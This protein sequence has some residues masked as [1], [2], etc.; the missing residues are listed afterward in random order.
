MTVSRNRDRRI[1]VR[2]LPTSLDS[3]CRSRW[4]PAGAV[5]GWHS[6]RVEHDGLAE[7]VTRLRRLV[8]GRRFDDLEWV[9]EVDSTNAV[10]MARAR[11]GDAEQALLTDF[12]SA[13]RGRRDRRW[14]APPGSSLMVSVLVRHGLDPDRSGHLTM[15]FGLAAADACQRCCGVRPQLKW[16]ND[17]VHEDRKLAGILAE[18][19][20]EGTTMTAAVIGMGMNTGWPQLPEDL[21]QTA[22]SLNLL[23]GEPIDRAELAALVLEHLEHWLGADPAHLRSAYTAHSATIGRRV[24]A[25]L[26]AGSSPRHAV[27]DGDGYAEGTAERITEAGHLVITTDRGELTVSAGDV[28]HLRPV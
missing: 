8:S 2:P 16:P 5:F 1:T 18:A 19:V 14:T 10:L 22:T 28:V 21:A 24:R 17:L 12:Q 11:E 26:P 13:G 27:A 9:A 15:A 4:S 6:G 20:I 23:A 3:G 25:Q 7:R